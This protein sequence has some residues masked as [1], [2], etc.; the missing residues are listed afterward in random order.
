[1]SNQEKLFRKQEPILPRNRDGKM[2]EGG[3]SGEVAQTVYIHVSKCKN[4]KIK[5]K[6]EKREIILRSMRWPK[7]I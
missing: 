4:D 1:M 5:E 7:I 3:R 2:K 6:N